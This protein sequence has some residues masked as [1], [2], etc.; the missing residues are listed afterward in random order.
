[1]RVE[2]QSGSHWEIL[3]GTSLDWKVGYSKGCVPKFTFMQALLHSEDLCAQLHSERHE[4]I[5]L[6]SKE[7]E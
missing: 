1:M 3:Y 6:V 2:D 7:E 4:H 5:G